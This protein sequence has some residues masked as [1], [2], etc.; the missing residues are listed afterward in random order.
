MQKGIL[1]EYISYVDSCRF[2]YPQY[3][4]DTHSHSL[5]MVDIH[6]QIFTAA[7]TNLIVPENTHYGQYIVPRYSSKGT[8]MFPRFL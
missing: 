2:H 4:I 8:C 7:L 6:M 3:A 5:G 1:Y